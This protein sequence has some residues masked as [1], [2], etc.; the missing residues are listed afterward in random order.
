M[1]LCRELQGLYNHW[2]SAGQIGRQG[3]GLHSGIIGTV[4]HT[5]K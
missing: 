3:G 1:S 4:R 2:R 5:E